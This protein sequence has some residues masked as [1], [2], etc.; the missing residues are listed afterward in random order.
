MLNAR[1]RT[2]VDQAL[3]ELRAEGFD[4]KPEI[5]CTISMRYSGQNYEHEVPVPDGALTTETLQSLFGE[6]HRLHE[7]FY[8]Y[9]ISG[10]TIELI[11]LSATVLGRTPK[12]QL[13]RLAATGFPEAFATRQ[14][15][16]PATG[17]VPCPIF[18]REDLP[19]GT[20]LTG[21]AIVEEVDSTL[22][23][24]PGRP[25]TVDTIG[26]IGIRL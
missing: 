21:P 20:K 3:A 19:P 6:F 8:G 11:R 9:S 23:L 15:Y 16:F 4:G 26:I 1:L 10:E 13:K 12:P 17:F 18:R 25:L 24:D 2:L 7:Q 5:R 14:V 22:V